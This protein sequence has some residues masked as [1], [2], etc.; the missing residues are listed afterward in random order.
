MA[1]LN[2]FDEDDSVTDTEINTD[3]DEKDHS[4]HSSLE[5]RRKIE[6]LLEAKRLR[7]AL[8]DFL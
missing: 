6:D 7:L 3:I 4:S 8:D 2:D 1:K 5:I